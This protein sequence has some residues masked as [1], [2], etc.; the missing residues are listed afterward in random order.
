MCIVRSAHT[1]VVQRGHKDVL[2]YVL[3]NTWGESFVTKR[4]FGLGVIV[5]ALFLLL[6]IVYARWQGNEHRASV[7]STAA[8]RPVQVAGQNGSLNVEPLGGL[9]ASAATA[10]SAPVGVESGCGDGDEGALHYDDEGQVI[11]DGAGSYNP[12][13]AAGPA[14]NAFAVWVENESK[15]WVNRFDA[16]SVSWGR[17]QMLESECTRGLV[18]TGLPHIAIDPS[19]NVFVVWGR[20]GN[21]HRGHIWGARYDV[22][23]GIWGKA[24]LIETN[25]ADDARDPQIAVDGNGNAFAIWYQANNAGGGPDKRSHIWSNRY[26]AGKGWDSAKRIDGDDATYSSYPKIAADR[27][28]NAVAVWTEYAGEGKGN[29]IMSRRYDG[30]S[31]MWTRAALIDKEAVNAQIAFDSSGNLSAV[32]QKIGIPGTSGGPSTLWFNRYSIAPDSWGKA[33]PVTSGKAGD[34]VSPQIALDKNAN[35]LVV[36]ERNAR[37]ME[38]GDQPGSSL[39]GSRYMTGKG[40]G[41]P[42]LIIA[43]EAEH[44][45]VGVDGDGNALAVWSAK[46]GAHRRIW[47]NRYVDGKGWGSATLLETDD[48]GDAIHPQVAIDGS[49]NGIA[50]WSQSDGKR[51]NIVVNRYVAGK[52]RQAPIKIEHN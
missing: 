52:G 11:E 43:G 38:G 10:V 5:V 25:N 30:A 26:I 14:G 18:R 19:G 21:D 15:I 9:A 29:N 1:E 33:Q 45:G 2:C 27:N 44:F 37:G 48:A 6:H 4:Y 12:E 39:W 49:G 20:D 40:W 16:A 50:I 41:K 24:I 51:R 47:F 46:S 36:W 32:W 28:G 13:V 3:K 42:Q 35:L 23:G 34:S 22:T 8:T 31:G 17:A 7:E